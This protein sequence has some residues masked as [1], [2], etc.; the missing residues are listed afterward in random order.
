MSGG[1]AC[2]NK[3]HHGHWVVRHYRCN[4]S[5]FNGYHRTPSEYSQVWC[6]ICPRM[7]RTKAGYV[8]SLPVVNREDLEQAIRDGAAAAE[9]KS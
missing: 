5:A 8:D 4:Y 2:R 6:P 9:E 7:W 1:Y 3:D